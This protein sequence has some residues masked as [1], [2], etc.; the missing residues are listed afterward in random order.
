MSLKKRVTSTGR[1]RG[2]DVEGKQTIS[3]KPS[4]FKGKAFLRGRRKREEKI[5][6][7]VIGSRVGD[8]HLCFEGEKKNFSAK[9]R[10]GAVP[11]ERCEEGGS[12]P[13]RIHPLHQKRKKPLPKRANFRQGGGSV[14]R[15]ETNYQSSSF[16]VEEKK[17][18]PR[19]L[20]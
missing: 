7:A 6:F 15:A 18:V 1:R 19:F 3:K 13:K 20:R 14:C 12:E 10:G 16:G 2:R 9:K 11:R 8:Y 5:V 17:K 4:S